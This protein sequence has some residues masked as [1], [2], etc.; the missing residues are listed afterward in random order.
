MKKMNWNK[1]KISALN[2]QIHS[3]NLMTNGVYETVK[4]TFNNTATNNGADCTT[5]DGG[6]YTSSFASGY[7]SSVS[8]PTASGNFHIGYANAGMISGSIPCS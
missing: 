2:N 7:A 8:V 1:P 3:A 4:F 5:Y 6:V